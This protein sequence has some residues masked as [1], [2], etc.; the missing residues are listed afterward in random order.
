MIMT[1]AILLPLALTAQ[2]AS[3]AKTAPV[4]SKPPVVRVQA[5]AGPVAKPVTPV[6]TQAPSPAAAGLSDRASILKRVET[7][8]TTVK[9][10]EGRFVQIDGYGSSTGR[11]YIQRPGKVRFDYATPE[12]MHIVSDGVSISIHEPKRSAWD[13]V[14]LST[15]PLNLFL[16]SNINLQ[17][18]ANISKVERDRGSVFVT[19]EDRS[20][21]AQGQMI[22]EFL[23]ADFSL[24]GWKAVDGGG[25]TTRVVLTDVRTNG[26]LKPGLFVVKDPSSRD[27]RRR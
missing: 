7:A 26:K 16:R 8:L 6:R 1:F 23:E 3:P 17:R 2:S 5:P 21:E 15:T 11:F 25:D 9:T 24:Q 14:P 12:T 27:D 20:G 13:A 10:A 22:L 4:A 19:M 18:D